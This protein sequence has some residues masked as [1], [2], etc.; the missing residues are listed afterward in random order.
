MGYDMGKPVKKVKFRVFRYDPEKDEKPHYSEY[1]IEAWKGMS[2]LDALNEIKAEQDPTLSWRQSCRM[3]VCGSCAMV[4]NGKPALACQTQVLKLDSDVITIEPLKS[5]P[6]IKDLAP[7]LQ[8]LFR[9]HTHVKPYI[10]RENEEELTE[11]NP[12]EEFLQSP[13]ELEAFLQFSYCIKCG[14]CVSACP[15]SQ[16]DPEFYGPQ[17]L[18]QAFR[19]ISDT[20]DEGEEIRYAIVD[21]P[22][23]C[24]R[25]HFA[26]SCTFV[27]PKGVD[28]AMAIQYLKR[29]LVLMSI[30]MKKEK[31]RAQKAPLGAPTDKVPEKYIPP[32]FTIAKPE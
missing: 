10:I 16:S 24:W 32:E 26:Q 3:G 1:T 4:I 27:C 9:H 15:V 6:V 20:R 18:A 29:D 12:T 8:N 28:P 23:G 21:N 22:Q 13:E 14:A 11:E 7:D 25:C 2:V 19:Y 31:K 5:F 30:G 17:A